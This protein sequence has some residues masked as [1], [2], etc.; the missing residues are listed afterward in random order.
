MAEAMFWL[1][2]DGEEPDNF[3]IA[4]AALNEIYARWGHEAAEIA[5]RALDAIDPNKGVGHGKA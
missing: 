4:L 3:G 2:K 5:A 1:G